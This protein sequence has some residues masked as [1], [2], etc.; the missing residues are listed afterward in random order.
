[1]PSNEVRRL[2][3]L[4]LDRLDESRLRAELA[5]A[6]EAFEA[7]T[8]AADTERKRLEEVAR[9]LTLE[10]AALRALPEPPSADPVVAVPDLGIL[11]PRFSA[12]ETQLADLGRLRDEQGRIKDLLE[13]IRLRDEAPPRGPAPV[14]ATED[15]V[16]S[17]A[18]AVA[19]A[20]ADLPGGL[21]LGAVEVDVRGPLG[22]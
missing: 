12:I 14:M 17:M 16:R 20:A 4:P 7:E 10:I 2:K 1:M 9:R 6:A 19:K 13:A 15:V 11:A 22:A 5:R 21:V 18:A 3:R 8:V